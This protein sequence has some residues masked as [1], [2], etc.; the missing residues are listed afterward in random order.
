MKDEIIIDNRISSALL[1]AYTG[2]FLIDLVQDCYIPAKRADKV[3]HLIKEID[4][5][6]EAMETAMRKTVQAEYL[7]KMLAFTNLDTLSDRMQKEHC[8]DQEYKGIISGWVRGS[9][10]EVER[11]S[12]GTVQKVLYTYRLIDE[13]RRQEI[14]E[15]KNLELQNDIEAIRSRNKEPEPGLWSMK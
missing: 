8:I 9:F 6:K 1:A 11:N 2:V 13:N 12:D 4:S 7:E 5:A 14:E 10:I 15:Q 3:F